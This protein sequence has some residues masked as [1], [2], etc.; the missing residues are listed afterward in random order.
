MI[1]VCGLKGMRVGKAC[2]SEKHANFIINEGGASAADIEQLIKLI[3]KRVRELTGVDL[4]PEVRIIGEIV[5]P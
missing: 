4:E 2:V 3:Q 5:V 1:D